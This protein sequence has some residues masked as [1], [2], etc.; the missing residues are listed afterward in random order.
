MGLTLVAT[1]DTQII[2]VVE[3][4]YKQTPGY[5]FLTNFRTFVTENSIDALANS[6]A[7]S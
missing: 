7:S 2:R 6:L 4:L 5:T 1:T 3:A